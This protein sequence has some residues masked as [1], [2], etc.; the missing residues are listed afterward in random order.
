MPSLG[1]QHKNRTLKPI[2][3]HSKNVIKIQDGSIRKLIKKLIIINKNTK[4]T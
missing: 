4:I 3:V 2:C 1:N